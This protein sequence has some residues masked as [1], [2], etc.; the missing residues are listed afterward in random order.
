MLIE[1]G[2]Y[3]EKTSF[4]AHSGD[5]DPYIINNETVPL[6]FVPFSEVMD[7]ND[8]TAVSYVLKFKDGSVYR[9]NPS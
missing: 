3:E 8:E 7:P 2:L 4:R 1:Q 5:L 6:K 9:T